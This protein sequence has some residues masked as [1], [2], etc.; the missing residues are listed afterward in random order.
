MAFSSTSRP[1]VIDLELAHGLLLPHLPRRLRLCLTS[2]RHTACI[3]RELAS[4]IA[5]LAP[6]VA[7]LTA[8]WIEAIDGSGATPWLEADFMRSNAEL[9][10]YLDA[11]ATE[12]DLSVLRTLADAAVLLSHS[13]EDSAA[14]ARL[15][16]PLWLEADGLADLR[17][18]IKPLARSRTMIAVA[19]PVDAGT[20]KPASDDFVLFADGEA[21]DHR[22]KAWA[23]LEKAW[24]DALE[25]ALLALQADAAAAVVGA[26]VLAKGVGDDW[27][28]DVGLGQ[29]VLEFGR[30]LC[31]PVAE[32]VS[33]KAS[34][35]QHELMQQLSRTQ[36]ALRRAKEE[37]PARDRPDGSRSAADGLSAKERRGSE[38]V[39]PGHLLAVP[40]V[41]ENSADKSKSITR[42]YETIVGRAIPLVATPDLATVRVALIQEFPY[43]QAAIDALLSDL[44]GR[45]SVRLHPTV[46]V[47]PPGAGKSRLA[48]RVAEL[49]S[50]GPWRVDGSHDGASF[51]GGT[52]RRWSSA[53]PSHAVMA[54]N[55][56]GIGNPMLL[57]DE[58][59]KAPTRTDYGRLW[60]TL[61]V[62]MEP[63]TAR[64]YMDPAFQ[65]EVDL[66]HISWLATANRVET[67]PGP[68]LDR[69]RVI[70]VPAPRR[71]DLGALLPAVLAGIARNQGIDARFLPPLDGEEGRALEAAWRG[72]SVRQLTRLVEAILALRG[73][74]AP[75][76]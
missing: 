20:D 54:M 36:A 64:N 5:R 39:P 19:E 70:A 26:A 17:H 51:L 55:R 35:R 63:A 9:I 23:D 66:S 38:S 27:V 45:S 41:Q 13:G 43:A 50:L 7:D 56:F 42:G 24:T 10:A 53:E 30:R 72:G 18:L 74:D 14:A 21:H 58:I 1:P 25:A 47:G 52:D 59:E 37:K 8:A 60:D 32:Q 75:R 28:A 22:L 46:L 12:R 48:A 49:L 61:L 65:V 62:M 73:T 3:R 57:V 71:A 2:N 4:E 15:A 34:L 6:D 68:L 69:M 11:S 29:A 31:A 16:R 40:W 44:V 76:H 33:R 67:L